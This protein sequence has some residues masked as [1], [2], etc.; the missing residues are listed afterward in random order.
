MLFSVLKKLANT[1]IEENTPFDLR[2][3]LRVFNNANI[4]I[5][6]INLFYAFI[7]LA[8]HYYIAVGVTLFCSVSN[9]I[10]F[11]LVRAGKYNLSF[12][13]T[14]W[15]GYIFLTAFSLLFGGAS[16]SY[17]YFLFVPVACNICFDWIDLFIYIQS[18]IIIYCIFSPLIPPI[19]KMITN[20]VS[21]SA[22]TI[23]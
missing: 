17:Y 13:F 9:I 15:Y 3:K 16:N 8:Q 19:N 23:L 14:I 20:R 7:G 12:H 22:I 11:F 21:L 1:G 10:A 5:F 6:F 2:N 18:Y 4:A